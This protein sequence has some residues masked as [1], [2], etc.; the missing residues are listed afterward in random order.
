MQS[1]QMPGSEKSTD[2]DRH[3]PRVRR[4]ARQSSPQ[5]QGLITAV[6]SVH[7]CTLLFWAI[8][9]L[10]WFSSIVNNPHRDYSSTAL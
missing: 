5:I 1:V 3:T 9:C 2:P 4:R 7:A 6:A 10:S 8:A